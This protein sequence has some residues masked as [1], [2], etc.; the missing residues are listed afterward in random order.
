MNRLSFLFVIGL[1]SVLIVGGMFGY[2]YYG[3]STSGDTLKKYDLQISSLENDL[4]QFK[5]ESLKAA[6]SAKATLDDVKKDNIRWSAVIEKVLLTTPK[7]PTTRAPVVEYMSYSAS[8]NSDIS[9]SVRT[10]SGSAAPFSDV[11]K[12]IRAFSNSEYFRNPFVP[13]IST[14]TDKVGNMTLVFNFNVDFINKF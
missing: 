7:D 4:K 11:A 3:S 10:V 9:I 13:S 8:Q 6:L 12:L 2:S 5:G 1:L 14:S